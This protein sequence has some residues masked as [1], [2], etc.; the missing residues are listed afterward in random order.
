VD[1]LAL[2]YTTLAWFS[3]LFAFGMVLAIR[4]MRLPV[5]VLLPMLLL[6][7]AFAY[8]LWSLQVPP[9]W[10][11]PG[12]EVALVVVNVAMTIVCVTAAFVSGSGKP[13]SDV[14]PIRLKP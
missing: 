10:V 13:T 9:Q 5:R 4:K 1:G 6:G 11:L 12:S 7:D 3:L 14:P 2:D 8:Y